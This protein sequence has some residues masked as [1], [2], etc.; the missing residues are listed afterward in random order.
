MTDPFGIVPAGVDNETFYWGLGLLLAMFIA[1]IISNIFRKSN[2][3]RIPQEELPKP[4]PKQ[5][6]AK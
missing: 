4:K 3:Q 1:G 6:E 2:L 5:A